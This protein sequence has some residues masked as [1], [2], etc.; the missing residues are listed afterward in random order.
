MFSSKNKLQVL[1]PKCNLLHK[2][3]YDKLNKNKRELN[4]SKLKKRN[5]SELLS[6]KTNKF[7]L[8]NKQCQN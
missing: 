5:F 1:E 3:F 2:L 7:W 8:F 6:K 4:F